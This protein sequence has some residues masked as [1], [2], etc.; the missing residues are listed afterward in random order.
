MY[1]SK[2]LYLLIKY[3]KNDTFINFCLKNP[4]E[5]IEKITDKCIRKLFLFLSVSK[6][7]S[8]K[9]FSV[10][11]QIN[12]WPTI[13]FFLINYYCWRSWMYLK[14]LENKLIFFVD[15]LVVM[16]AF[17]LYINY[18]SSSSRWL[19]FFSHLPSILNTVFFHLAC[20]THKL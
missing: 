11:K 13:S 15:A 2:F 9:W 10:I 14:V 6:T 17:D 20:Q 7:N 12:P 1:L 4:Q 18:K 16:K 5:C 3:F 8:S 19:C